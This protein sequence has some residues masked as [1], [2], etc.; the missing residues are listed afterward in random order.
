MLTDQHGMEYPTSDGKP[1]AETDVHRDQIIA[2]ILSLQDRYKERP[3]VYVTG[4]LLMLY[5][6][7]DGRQHLSP[8]VMVVFGVDKK[9][10]ENYK[11]WEEKPPDAVFEITSRSTRREDTGRKMERYA[12]EGVREYFVFDP[13]REYIPSGLRAYRL[14]A[15]RYIPVVGEPIRSEV[16]GLELRIVDGVLRLYD[17]DSGELLTVHAELL[18]KWRAAE[19]RAEVAEARAEAAEQRAE[20]A[21]AALRELE[22]LKLKPEEP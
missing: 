17:P 2:L 12:Q 6:P 22:A 7:L 5:E 14:E 16:L 13:L 1:M 10:R 19:A 15:G 9:Q 8:D 3:D 11:L 21:E 18:E 20:R 4:N